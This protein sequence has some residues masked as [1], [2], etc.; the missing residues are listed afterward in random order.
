MSR[1]LFFYHSSIGKKVI[2]AL[3]GVVL[4]GFVTVHMVGNLKIFQGQH[5]TISD[6]FTRFNLIYILPEDN[7]TVIRPLG[8]QCKLFR[9]IFFQSVKDAFIC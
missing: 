8:D 3:T 6:S 5:F 7:P 2:M 1:I 9:A 4:F